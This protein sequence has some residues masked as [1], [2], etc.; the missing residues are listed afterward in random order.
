MGFPQRQGSQDF[1]TMQSQLAVEHDSIHFI[2]PDPSTG[3]RNQ[4]QFRGVIRT[5]SNTNR[6]EGPECGSKSGTDQGCTSE[7]WWTLGW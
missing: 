4:F 2:P 1:G 7:A 5:S 6:L 3:Q